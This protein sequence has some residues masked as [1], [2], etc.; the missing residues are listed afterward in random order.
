MGHHVCKSVS[1]APFHAWCSHLF[2]LKSTILPPSLHILFTQL[3][4]FSLPLEQANLLF[5]KKGGSCGDFAHL[6]YMMLQIPS[7]E[8]SCQIKSAGT[9]CCCWIQLQQ[10]FLCH[11]SGQGLECDHLFHQRSPDGHKHTPDESPCQPH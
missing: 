2:T 11:R 6:P 4:T 10:V 3:L 8:P 5:L 1:A 7:F 9:F